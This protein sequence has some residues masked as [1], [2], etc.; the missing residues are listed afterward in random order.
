MSASE[1]PRYEPPQQSIAGQI[2]DSILILALV[3][4][5]LFAPV[6]FKLAADK[7]INLTF[8]S[9]TWK[10]MGQN[11]TA[12]AQWQKLGLTPD[13]AH[14]MIASRFDYTFSWVM[15]AITAVVIIAYFLFVIVVS[16][17]EY[18]GVIAERFGSDRGRR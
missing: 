4:A 18:K 12:Q 1:R 9:N 11:E 15:F 2:A 6:Y 16:D 17:K 7:R 10:A 5:S 13:T 8:A 3:T 14:D